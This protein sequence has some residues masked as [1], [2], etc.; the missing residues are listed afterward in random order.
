MKALTF[1]FLL[2]FAG[3][4]F[5][6]QERAFYANTNVTSGAYFQ[7]YSTEHGQKIA[8]FTI[9]LRITIPFTRDLIL[10]VVSN[11]AFASMS[12]TS[13]GLSG[14]TDTRLLGSYVTADDHLLIT[15]GIG[16]P[17]GAT[18]LKDDEPMI[19][20]ALSQYSLDFRVPSFGQGLTANLGAAYAFE[21]GRSTVLGVGAGAVYKDGFKPY[22]GQS[23]VYKPGAEV[24]V[25][26][27]GETG[28]KNFKIKLDVVYTLYGEDT[29]DNVEILKSGDKIIANIQAAY[30]TQGANIIVYARNRTK[31]KNERGF[32]S[33]ATERFNSNGNQFDAGAVGAIPLSDNYVLKL[34][35]ESRLHTANDYGNN[36]AAIFGGGA[37][38]TANLADIFL[39]DI[40]AKYFNGTIENSGSSVAIDGFETGATVRLMI[41]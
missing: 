20:S 24:S 12:G 26:A 30:R 21:L 7:S 19:A 11:Q 16:L 38:F 31:G 29:F 40:V 6:Q 5:A 9:P 15:A 32:G 22:D 33:L 14:L 23:A 34:Y 25:N 8:E 18:S 1:F 4:L 39:L 37:G 41:R 2:L 17:T 28:S 36:G 27:G 13:G 10:N 35:L 3:A